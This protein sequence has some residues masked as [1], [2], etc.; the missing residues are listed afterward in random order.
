MSFQPVWEKEPCEMEAAIKWIAQI[1]RE[2]I[3]WY[4]TVSPDACVGNQDCI[5]LCP[6]DVFRWDPEAGH[7]VVAAPFNCVVGCRE[8]VE[9]CLNQA[10]SFPS[11]EEWLAVLHRLQ[12][13]VQENIQAS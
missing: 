6:Q 8:C 9:V 7:V 10:I 5:A 2:E 3:P 13:R 1:P 4:P 11:V 12:A